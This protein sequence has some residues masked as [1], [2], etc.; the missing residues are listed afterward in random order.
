[1]LGDRQE[2]FHPK[3]K[4]MMKNSLKGI[5]LS[6]LVFPGVGQAALRHY[7]R[8]IAFILTASIILLVLVVKAAQHAITILEKIEAGG[9]AID[10]NTMTNVAAQASTPS[11]GLTFKLLVF[12]LVVMWTLGVVDAYRVGKKK[13][14]EEAG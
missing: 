2:H 14:I 11:G 9:G 13:D 3:L 6:G 8:G 4:R 5:L 12:L 10:I 1:M 7:K